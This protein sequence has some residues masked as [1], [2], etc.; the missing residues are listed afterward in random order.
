MRTN[1]VWLTREMQIPVQLL[2]RALVVVPILAVLLLLIHWRPTRQV[3][4]HQEH[5]FEAVGSRDWKKVGGFLAADYKDRWGQTREVAL[6]RL[7]QAFQDFLS[8]SVESEKRS[9]EWQDGACI[10]KSRIRILGSG[11]GIARYVMAELDQLTEPFALTWRQ[12]S[13]LPWDWALVSV[14]QPQLK[15]SPDFEMNF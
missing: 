2:R 3:R 8:C 12:Q 7:P 15:F 13:W 10:F 1:H 9:I 6:Q 5:L 14:D 11:G 4:L